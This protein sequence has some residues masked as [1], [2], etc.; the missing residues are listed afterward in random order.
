MQPL[1]DLEDNEASIPVIQKQ[2]GPVRC[3]RCQAYVNPYFQFTNGGRSFTCNLCQMSNEL[4]ADYVCN[5]DMNGRRMDIMERPELLFGSY[6]FS[7]GSEYCSKPPV[8]ASY[9][10]AVDVSWPAIQNGM[11]A[12]FCSS[13]KY[14]LYSSPEPLAKG[15]KVGIITYD[16]SINFFNLKPE[17]ET[18]QMMVVNDLDDVFSPIEEGLLVDPLASRALIESLLDA[19]P[20]IFGGNRSPEAAVGSACLCAFDALKKFGGKLSVFHCSLPNWSQGILQNRDDP[21]SMNTDKERHLYEP[22]DYF[23]VKFGQNCATVGINIDLYLFP[24]A[25]IDVSTLGS[26]SALS[27]GDTYLYTSFDANQHGIKFANDLQRSLGRNFGFDSVLRIRVSNGFKIDEYYGNFH[28]KNATDIECAGIDSLKSIVATLV[29]DGTFDERQE[30]Y[31]QAALLYTTADGHRRVRLHNLALA[32]SSQLS[33]VFKNASL[34]T[35]VC[36]MTRKMIQQAISKSLQKVRAELSMQCTNILM[37]YRSNVAAPS[38]SGQ[39]ILPESFK[40]FPIFSLSMLKTRAFRGARLQSS[41]TRVY[42]MRV[43]NGLSV[44]E[45]VNYLYPTVYDCSEVIPGLL[46]TGPEGLIMYPVLR[47]S[48][49]RLNSTGMYIAGM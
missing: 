11:L 24:N 9:L 26:I 37:S 13:L 8:P 41:D 30:V 32:C 14:F 22:Q 3:A 27:G 1:A 45:L 7:V 21:K 33:T 15:A 10:F 4:P 31:I 19:L 35:A 38:S 36:V 25:Y 39:L 16:K 17:L 40:L 20:N 42:S 48:I 12:T 5:L 2:T 28:M 46:T 18:F 34:D 49:A 23:W 6:E 29:H 43:L 44:E 47:A